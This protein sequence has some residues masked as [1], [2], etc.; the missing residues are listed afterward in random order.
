LTAATCN[1]RRDIHRKP[2]FHNAAFCTT[3]CSCFLF[4]SL[5]YFLPDFSNVIVKCLAASSNEKNYSSVYGSTAL[6]DL[7]RFFSFLIYIQSVGLHGRGIS[8]SQDR[9]LHRTTQTQNKHTQTSVP[10]VG[11]KPTIPVFEGACLRPRGRTIVHQPKLLSSGCDA[12]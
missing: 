11:F 4:P 9:Y 12:V 10:R 3:V 7:C 8:P 5:L 6:V 2:M 1:K